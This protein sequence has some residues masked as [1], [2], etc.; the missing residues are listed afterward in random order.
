[1]IKDTPYFRSGTVY[2]RNSLG[3]EK[4]VYADL[5]MLSSAVAAEIVAAA[6]KSIAAR[7]QFTLVLSGGSTP[8]RLYQILAGAPAIAILWSQIQIFGGDERCVPVGDPQSNYSMAHQNLL[9]HIAIP[10]H[11]IHRIPADIDPPELAASAYEYLL[12]AGGAS[13]KIEPTGPSFDLV[14]LGMGADGHT[15]SL[16]PNSPALAEKE[17]WTLPLLAPPV[18]D[19]RQ[20]ITLTF[21]V[22][23]RS[24]QIFFLVSGTDKREPVQS[25]FADPASAR[26]GYPAAR[27]Q[28]AWDSTQQR[29]AWFLDQAAAG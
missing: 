17:R 16:F 25:I 23:N 4:H 22:I 6:Q 12:R 28:A 15:A 9:A 10:P 18:H 29:I 11:N 3:A 5:E 21:P 27:V 26:D 19:A 14:L 13:W 1:M 8:R 7:G 2:R 20:R 24:R